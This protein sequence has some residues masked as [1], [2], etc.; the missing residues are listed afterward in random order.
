[1]SYYWTP[2]EN[3]GNFIFYANIG[4]RMSKFVNVLNL[5][6]IITTINMYAD[7]MVKEY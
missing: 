5:I 6:T 1:M 3:L 7:I 2:G 4:F